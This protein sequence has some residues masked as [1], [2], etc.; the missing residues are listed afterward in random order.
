MENIKVGGAETNAAGLKEREIQ[1]GRKIF[2]KYESMK[3]TTIIIDVLVR[4]GV[5]LTS[6]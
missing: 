3:N 5:A 6:S 4:V 1:C 2:Q